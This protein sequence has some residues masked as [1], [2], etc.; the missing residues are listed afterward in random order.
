[1]S[2]MDYNIGVVVTFKQ[3]DNVEM[4]V[5]L[6]TPGLQFSA[7]RLLRS[8]D[9]RL[10]KF[11]G[12]PMVFPN[13]DDLPPDVPRM[14]L[15]SVD[16]AFRLQAS[17]KR[18]DVFVNKIQA[19]GPRTAESVL[20]DVGPIL[21]AYVQATNA[22]VNRIA[23][24]RKS[25]AR[26]DQPAKAMATHFCKDRWISGPLNR[27]ESFEIHAHK[28]YTLYGSLEVN[29]WIRC[30]TA[31]INQ[32]SNPPGILVE[33]DCNTLA[34]KVRDFSLPE[35]S[36]FLAAVPGSFDETLSLYFPLVEENLTASA[37][38]KAND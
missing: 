5:V 37:E 16:G 15:T 17:P 31:R 1:M 30:K 7:A 38:E 11:D 8:D 22:V 12:E 2:R 13:A 20:A 35:I 3:F 28:V 21:E 33:Q 26:M 27:P 34:D 23:V 6:F 36:E 19:A 24:V 25:L 29:S 32:E 4:Q 10:L 14:I 9:S 18:V